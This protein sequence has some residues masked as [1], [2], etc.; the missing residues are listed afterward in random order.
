[1]KLFALSLLTLALAPIPHAFA[2]NGSADF[3]Y[4]DVQRHQSGI[5]T[6]LS[7]AAQCLQDDLAK[8]RLFMQRYG[9]SAFYGENA[10]FAKVESV[11]AWG[12][13][14]SRPTTAE[15]KRDQLRAYGVSEQIV[16]QLVPTRA[17]RKASDCPLEMQPASCVGL[18][19][20][21]LQRGFAAA[22]QSDIWANLRQFT[23][24]NG[25]TG[26]SLQYG[27]QRLGW[28]LVYWN[29]NPALDRAWDAS[30]RAT[31]P[32]N[33]LS[34]WGRH[35]E[36]YRSVMQSRVYG[37]LL[38]DDDTS[39]VGFG[40]GVPEIA[41]R[42]PFFVGIAHMGY[43]VF[44]GTYGQVVEAHSTRQ[45]ND[46]KEIQSSAFSPLTPGAG[47][48]GGPRSTLPGGFASDTYRSGVIA[49]PPGY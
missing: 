9:V 34:I 23:R 44:P 48:Q 39:A 19:L 43:H 13:K 45:V 30:E 31:Y 20:K 17:C 15:E 16:E 47:P 37:D 49:I 21:C 22:G 40:T 5:A 26:N 27:L 46:P 41:R 35:D 7:T 18:A 12:Q 6:I 3:S 4:Y 2:F 33:P 38:V 25:V 28:K 1:M 8:H 29:P 10:S 32:R 11:D 24:D 42:A 14:T 36:N